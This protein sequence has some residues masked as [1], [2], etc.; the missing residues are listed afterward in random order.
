MRLTS[1]QKKFVESLK[2]ESD[3]LWCECYYPKEWR[4]AKSLQAKDLIE[5]M[6]SEEHAKRLGRFEARLIR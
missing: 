2:G 6:D 4:T 1:V 5:I 3:G